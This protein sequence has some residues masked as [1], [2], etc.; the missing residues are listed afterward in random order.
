[1]EYSE[2]YVLSGEKD[3]YGTTI[4]TVGWLELF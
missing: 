4:A 2:I 3:L 1:M